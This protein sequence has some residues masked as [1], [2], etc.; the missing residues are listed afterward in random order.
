MSKEEIIKIIKEVKGQL[1]EKYKV[2]EIGLFGSVVREEQK[3]KSDIDL[4]VD[5]RDD[6]DIFDLVG[7]A[8]F[9]EEKLGHKVDIVPRRALRKEIKDVVLN[10]LVPV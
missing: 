2:E 4:L 9:L 5:F 6:A 8:L 1:R 3:G 7:L 10:E